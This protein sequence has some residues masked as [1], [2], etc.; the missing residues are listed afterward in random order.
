MM[1]RS[2]KPIVRFLEEME[3]TPVSKPRSR[4]GKDDFPRRE[5]AFPGT[6]SRFRWT[7]GRFL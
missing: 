2:R 7:I 1:Q 4:Q 6:E 3:R 5:R